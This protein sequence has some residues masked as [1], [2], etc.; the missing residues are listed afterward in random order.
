MWDV[1]FGSRTRYPSWVAVAMGT[2]IGALGY[3]VVV[4]GL[5]GLADWSGPVVVLLAPAVVGIVAE[6]VIRAGWGIAG[7]A[8]GTILAAQVAPLVLAD[9]P[10]VDITELVLYL[11]AGT[12]GYTVGAGILLAPTMPDFTPPPSTDIVKAERDVRRQLRAL[13]PDAPGSFERAAVLLRRVNDEVQEHTG[14]RGGVPLEKDGADAAAALLELQAEVVEATRVAAL[15]AGARR[16]TVRSDG[17]GGGIDV[18]AVFGE[19]V[20]Q[21]DGPTRALTDVD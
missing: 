8:L 5:V 18:E 20:P 7:L 14:W 13:D 10:P 21:D 9:V 1:R 4:G 17:A 11:A 15:R 12:I 19:D 2:G 6:L 3:L 16:V